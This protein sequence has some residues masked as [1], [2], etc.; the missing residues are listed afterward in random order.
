MSPYVQLLWSIHFR[1]PNE[2]DTEDMAWRPCEKR[3]PS[4]ESIF[5]GEFLNK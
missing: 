5:A 3:G 1:L 2:H 4:Y